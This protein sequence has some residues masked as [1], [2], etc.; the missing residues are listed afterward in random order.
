MSAGAASGASLVMTANGIASLAIGIYLA[1][2][3][4]VPLLWSLAVVVVAFVF[5]TGCLLDRRMVWIATVL[6]GS[7]NAGIGAFMLAALSENLHSMAPGWPAPWASCWA[8]APRSGSTATPP[9]SP[10]GTTE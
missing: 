3:V 4:E 10:G 8:F 9:A 2:E 6:G 5:L 1:M 7:I